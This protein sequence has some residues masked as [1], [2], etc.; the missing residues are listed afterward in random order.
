MSRIL[1]RLV[2]LPFDTELSFNKMFCFVLCLS[3]VFHYRV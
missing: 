1:F 2:C 3:H